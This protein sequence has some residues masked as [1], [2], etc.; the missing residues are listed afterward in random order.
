LALLGFDF[1][2]PAPGVTVFLVADIDEFLGVFDFFVA[3]DTI[4]LAGVGIQQ[5]ILREPLGSFHM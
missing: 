3:D 2:R 4:D 5:A 1:Y